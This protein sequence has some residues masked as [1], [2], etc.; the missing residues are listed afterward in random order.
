[1]DSLHRILSGQAVTRTQLICGG[2]FIA[3]WSGSD[4]IMFTDFVMT[5]LG[6]NAVCK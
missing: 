5:K 1:M 4:F 2:I 3:I 6:L